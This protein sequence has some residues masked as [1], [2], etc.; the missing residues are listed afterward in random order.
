M[1]GVPSM[2]NAT[3]AVNPKTVYV[4]PGTGSDDLAITHLVMAAGLCNDDPGWDEFMRS[5]A[6]ARQEGEAVYFATLDE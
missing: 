2:T 6:E 3:L 1:S 5:V 4:M